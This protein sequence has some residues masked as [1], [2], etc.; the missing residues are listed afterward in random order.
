MGVSR[1]AIWKHVNAL[2]NQ[3]YIIESHPRLG[4]KLKH[5]PDLLLPIEI[6]ACLKSKILGQ[7]VYHF[8]S[9]GSTQEYAFELGRKGTSEG[10]LVVAEEQTS[11]H[12]RKGRPYCSP[13]GGIWFSLLLRPPL[14]PRQ[15]PVIS[16]AAGV[17][18]AEVVT[19]LGLQSVLLRWPNDILIGGKKL[20]GILAEMSAEPDQLHFV[21]LGMGINA[22][23]EMDSLPQAIR[24]LATTLKNELG[25]RVDRVEIL[26]KVLE[27]LEKYYLRLLKQG[28]ASILE[29][30]KS[31]PNMLGKPVKVSAPEGIY[32]GVAVGLDEDGALLIKDNTGEVRKLFA[33][34]VSVRAI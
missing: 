18:L 23:V 14:P 17:A 34:D 16:L 7:R 13:Q 33:G 21:V 15:A 9:I 3:G 20:S 31:F 4:H 19:G 32:D 25:E 22:N 27:K 10:A 26:C 28:P 1:T 5:I 6:K 8:A 29:D 24:P 30:W 12:G 2:R 11:G